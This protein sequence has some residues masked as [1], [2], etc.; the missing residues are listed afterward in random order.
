M[1]P[2][3]YEKDTRTLFYRYSVHRLYKQ[4]A[5]TADCLVKNYTS[6]HTPK[7]PLVHN[8]SGS[9]C[10]TTPCIRYGLITVIMC[11]LIKMILYLCLHKVTYLPY[12]LGFRIKS[13]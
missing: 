7:S 12:F 8:I 1:L 3:K 2:P 6:S 5:K 11:Y 4:E 9:F 13:S 10:I